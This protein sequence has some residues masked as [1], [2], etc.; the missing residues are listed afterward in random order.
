MNLIYFFS[1]VIVVYLFYLFFVILKKDKLE[2]FKNSSSARIIINMG[3]LKNVDN[4]VLANYVALA[5]G[6]IIG[7]V[8]V[9]VTMFDNLYIMLLVS[10]LSVIPV[11]CLIYFIVALIL[12]RRD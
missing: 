5:N 9:F 3:K 2:Q 11:T 12:K 1:V 8:A 4:K 6:T 7:L 10:A